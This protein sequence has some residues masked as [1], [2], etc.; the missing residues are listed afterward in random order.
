MQRTKNRGETPLKCPKNGVE[1]PPEVLQMGW[2]SGVAYLKGEGVLHPFF[3]TSAGWAKGRT[4]TAGR[5]TRRKP[6]EHREYEDCVQDGLTTT[7]D[8]LVTTQ[9]GLITTQDGLVTPPLWG[10][11]ADL[12]KKRS[13]SLNNAIFYDF[14]IRVLK[15]AANHEKQVF[16]FFAF[17]PP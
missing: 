13:K 14:S 8:G 4:S 15:L 10:L 12:F 17:L 16:T 1:T 11:C 6:D 9:D 2:T 5:S 3:G 7:Q